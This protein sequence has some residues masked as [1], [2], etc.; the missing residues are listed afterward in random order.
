MLS[1]DAFITY[2]QAQN[3]GSKCTLWCSAL[4]D[5]TYDAPFTSDMIQTS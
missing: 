2:V 1:D 3:G 5:G 4:S